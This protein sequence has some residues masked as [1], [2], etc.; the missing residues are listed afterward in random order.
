ME[1]ALGTPLWLTF[2]FLCTLV[3]PIITCSLERQKGII[4]GMLGEDPVTLPSVF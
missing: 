3:S 2:Y 1:V 4:A